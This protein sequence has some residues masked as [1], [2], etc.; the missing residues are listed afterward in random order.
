MLS[1]P[2]RPQRPRYLFFVSNVAPGF[3]PA[4]CCCHSLR[5]AL[6]ASR[7]ISREIPPSPLFLAL[8][9][10][11]HARSALWTPVES[12]GLS[13]PED[14]L[15]SA[16]S[17]FC[18]CLILRA[19][20]EGWVRI[21]VFV[22]NLAP[23]FSPAS[24]CCHSLRSVLLRPVVFAGRGAPS[25]SRVVPREIPPPPSSDKRCRA[26]GARAGANAP[27]ANMRKMNTCEK[28]GRGHPAFF[29]NPERRVREREQNQQLRKRRM[30]VLQNEHLRESGPRG[31][32]AA[33]AYQQDELRGVNKVGE[34]RT[35]GSSRALCRRTELNSGGH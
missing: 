21:L 13:V 7:T 30:Q 1:T 2:G 24:C 16:F 18:G 34:A 4:S 15:F 31:A 28:T 12:A 23:G 26:L 19:V 33:N 17:C 27:Q 35:A 20:R 14:L 32:T 8:S 25:A 29:S 3:S 22:F 5:S 11:P 10:R 9:S 6:F